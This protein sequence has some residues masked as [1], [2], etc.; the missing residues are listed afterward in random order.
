M[1]TETEIA[2][3]ALQHIGESR[4]AS[5]DDP[6]DKVSRTCRVNFNQARDEALQ[7]ARWGC[8]KKQGSLSKLATAP[9]TKWAAAYQLPVDFLRLIE[10][11]GDDA[12]MPREYFDRLGDTLV[13]GRGWDYED[14]SESIII[15]Y[16]CRLTDCTRFEPL[17]VE[18]VAMLLAMKCAR[19]L[20]GSDS[21]AQEL[22]QEYEQV[23]L[24][25][26]VTANAAPIYSG[27]N[28][29]IR[30]VMRKSFMNRA[31]R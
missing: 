17:L 31:R 20:T 4:I 29:P 19:T 18:V 28:H 8:A 1:P 9:L 16:I 26:A 11:D 25:R 6:L 15:E 12:W 2:N 7:T 24:P 22:R 27:H 5:I 10:I 30:Q 14:V 13:L 23:V 21:K 3:L